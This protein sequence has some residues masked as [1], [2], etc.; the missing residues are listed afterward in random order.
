MQKETNKK[1][2][3]KPEETD[4]TFSIE[5]LKSEFHKIRW[6]HLKSTR[7]EPGVAENSAKVIGFSGTIVAYFM[8]GGLLISVIL[9]AIGIA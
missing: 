2:T 1:N 8:A 7:N 3:A 4:R 5:G 9:R 6:P